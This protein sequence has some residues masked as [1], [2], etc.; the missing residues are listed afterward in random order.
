[1]IYTFNID[2]FGKPRMVR[3]DAWSKRECVEK[4][5]SFKDL[6]NLEANLNK[7]IL[8][9]PLCISFHIPMP[10][11]W[12]EKKKH[13]KAF[14]YHTQKPDID[15]LIKSFMDS[16]STDDS[17]ISEIHAKKF[18]SYEGFIEVLTEENINNF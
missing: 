12:S 5:Y 14:T 11:S 7:Y 3:S 9:S 2:P 13:D 18:W 4:Y 6:L 15:N 8:K 10:E 16:L 1:M 17:G